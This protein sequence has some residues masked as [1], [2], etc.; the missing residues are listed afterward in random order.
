MLP[1]P[2]A[3][4]SS[5]AAMPSTGREPALS[6]SHPNTGLSAYIP[7]TCRLITNPTSCRVAPP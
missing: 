6:T 1:T 2:P 3:A 4:T 7:A 5:T